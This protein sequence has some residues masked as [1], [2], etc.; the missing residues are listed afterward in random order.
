VTLTVSQ[1]EGWVVELTV[2]ASIH[3]SPLLRDI[4]DALTEGAVTGRIYINQTDQL[5]GINNE[6]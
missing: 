3:N 5:K 6:Q 1:V 4:A 2:M